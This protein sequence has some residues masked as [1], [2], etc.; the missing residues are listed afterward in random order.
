MSLL[1]PRDA[2]RGFLATALVACFML[3]LFWLMR[4]IVPE[5]NRDLVNF[6]L[7]QLSIMV[8][9]ALVFYFGTTKSSADKTD[10]IREQAQTDGPQHIDTQTGQP[11]P[12]RHAR[13]LPQ[14]TFDP[15]TAEEPAP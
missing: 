5:A 10:I 6:M 12:V 1:R 11:V 7:G 3:A 9:G 4:W 15:A 8:S 13:P 14:P 2:M